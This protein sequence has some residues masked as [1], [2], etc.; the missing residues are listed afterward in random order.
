MAYRDDLE[1]AVT[2]AESLGKEVERLSA[3]RATGDLELIK[4]R[5]R[6]SQAELEVARLRAVAPDS[7]QR[8]GAFWRG[9]L[10]VGLGLAVATAVAAYGSEQRG[11]E[12][13]FVASIPIG[14]GLAGRNG[15][16]RSHRHGLVAAIVGGILLP[17]LLLLFYE[18]IWE[19][20]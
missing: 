14:A 8:R 13:S 11:I 2:R 16:R 4:L 20:L 3:E 19:A 9:T 15:A 10:L 1:A 18:L 17:A 12:M 5:L 6:L 7:P